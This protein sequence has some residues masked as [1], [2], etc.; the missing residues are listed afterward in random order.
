MMDLWPYLNSDYKSILKYFT[1][2][3]RSKGASCSFKRGVELDFQ[4][5]KVKKKRFLHR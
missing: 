3:S 4:H 2:F 5:F 1:S